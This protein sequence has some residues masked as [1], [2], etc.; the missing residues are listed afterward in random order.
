[1]DP[2]LHACVCKAFKD[3]IR[4]VRKI[5]WEGI[6]GCHGWRDGSA[7]KSSHMIFVTTYNSNSRGSDDLF[8]PPWAAE[9][10]WC[11]YFLKAHT[12]THTLKRSKRIKYIF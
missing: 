11:T 7:V 12:Q 8:R 9:C 5:L 10:T 1:M 2:S 6:G 4:K 3:V